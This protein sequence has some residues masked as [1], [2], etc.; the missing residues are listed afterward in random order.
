MLLWLCQWQANA[1]GTCTAAVT[2]SATS[3]TLDSCNTYAKWYTYTAVKSS[4]IVEA[5]SQSFPLG[6]TMEL[7]SG[8]CGSL[9]SLGKDSLAT[10]GDPEL[11]VAATATIGNTYYIKLSFP[12]SSYVRY[13][14]TPMDELLYVTNVN[15]L[16]SAV[17][18]VDELDA[19]P[20]NLCLGETLSVSFDGVSTSYPAQVLYGST[21]IGTVYSSSDI[22]Y[23]VP[24]TYGATTVSVTINGQLPP[25]N[26]YN[27]NFRTVKIIAYQ[28]PVLYTSITPTNVCTGSQVCLNL[29]NVVGN[30]P[31]SAGG[32]NEDWGDGVQ[33][34]RTYPNQLAPCP[35]CHAYTSAGTYTINLQMNN[36]ICPNTA[37]LSQVIQVT[38]PALTSL[39]YTNSACNFTF[40]A[41]STCNMSPVTY[42]WVLNDPNTQTFS[43][44]TNTLSYTFPQNGTYQV[45]VYA[46]SGNITTN[47]EVVYVTVNNPA[48]TLSQMNGICPTP[49]ST[50]TASGGNTYTWSPCSSGCNA[51]PFW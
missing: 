42:Q 17:C 12:T 22:I 43:T 5:Y 11:E 41:A 39:T 26:P 6:S 38:D 32:L 46:V 25:G 14:L 19:G 49:A 47:T 50:L 13:K 37:T 48:L 30:N 40:S 27:L 31:S 8:T 16:Q 36:G 45:T 33:C 2:V 1:Q 34:N 15:T 21:N 44:S 4:G 3:T 18:D 10:S 20:I 51:N 9:I 35:D 29:A 24:T 23:Y 7:F 28:N